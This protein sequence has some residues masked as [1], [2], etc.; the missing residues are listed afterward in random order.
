MVAEDQRVMAE[1]QWRARSQNKPIET[2][3]ICFLK[4]PIDKNPKPQG[5]G[6][7]DIYRRRSDESGTSWIYLAYDLW[8]RRWNKAFAGVSC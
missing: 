6:F 7:H 4:P 3:P 1:D 8:Y 2:I 5:V